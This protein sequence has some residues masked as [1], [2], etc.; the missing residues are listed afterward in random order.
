MAAKTRPENPMR[1]GVTV[2]AAAGW[3]GIHA[4][5]WSQLQQLPRHVLPADGSSSLIGFAGDGKALVTRN[6]THVCIWDVANGT[7]T[8]EWPESDPKM[9]LRFLSPHGRM[10]VAEDTNHDSLVLLDIETGKRTEL[11]NVGRA[12]YGEDAN[13]MFWLRDCPGFSPDGRMFAFA[14]AVPESKSFVVRVWDIANQKTSEIP[15]ERRGFSP[16]F[17]PDGHT[18]AVWIDGQDQAPSYVMLADA[19]TKREIGRLA[20]PSAFLI[21]LAFSPDRQTLAVSGLD[22][23]R[24]APPATISWFQLWDIPSRKLIHAAR[25]A[26]PVHWAIDGRLIV[27]KETKLNAY[28]IRTR[29]AVTGWKAPDLSGRRFFRGTVAGGRLA[30]IVSSH[31]SVPWT[32]WLVGKHILPYK[33][34]DNGRTA[35]ELYDASTGQQ[36]SVVW[37]KNYGQQSSL[38]TDGRV[39][40]TLE[41]NDPFLSEGHVFLW[42]IPPRNPGGIVLGLMIVEVALLIAWTAWRQRTSRRKAFAE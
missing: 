1:R 6:R 28:D 10:V 37:I 15:L 17:A 35:V 42:D 11:P 16:T 5:L 24:A 21:H 22:P 12:M 36:V 8:K 26:G 41:F 14:A 23:P 34:F 38:S 33:Y 20:T 13:K 9:S 29:A 31:S 7:V 19:T 3:L 25:S 18:L 2:L 30:L 32:N 40:A 27:A 4:A 39:L